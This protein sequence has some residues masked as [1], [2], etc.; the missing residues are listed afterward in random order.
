LLNANYTGDV[1]AYARNEGDQEEESDDQSVDY[2]EDD[3]VY[4]QWERMQ[5]RCLPEQQRV[6]DLEA[7]DFIKNG[8]VD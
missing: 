4:A 8:L 5:Q 1:I 6:M 7:L 3:T 2:N